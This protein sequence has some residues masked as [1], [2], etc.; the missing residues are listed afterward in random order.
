[1]HQQLLQI[2]AMRL[3]RHLRGTHL[4]RADDPAVEFGNQQQVAAG[5]NGI[6]DITPI[7]L[8]ILR[9][10]GLHEADGGATRDAIDKHLRKSR[11]GGAG[12]LGGK[13]TNSRH[14]VLLN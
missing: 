6:G 4:H 9:P 8:G 2:T 12:L 10:I 3:V 11:N 13:V 14:A 1:M 5:G 7:G